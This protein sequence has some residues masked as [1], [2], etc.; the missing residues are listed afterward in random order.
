MCRRGSW[1]IEQRQV[2]LVSDV[3]WLKERHPQWKTLG[4][5]AVVE[6]HREIKGKTETYERRT[7]PA[8]RLRP[9]NLSRMQYAAIGIL[10]RNYTGSW[11]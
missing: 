4:G 6:S 9:L 11:M 10:N 2:W 3:S 5:I 1:R 7:S 8:I